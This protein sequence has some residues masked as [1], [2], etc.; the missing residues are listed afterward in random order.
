MVKLLQ[1]KV[2]ALEN[3]FIQVLKQ[4]LSGDIMSLAYLLY[5][6]DFNNDNEVKTLEEL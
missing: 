2:S 5:P 1:E 4:V 6:Q 3:K